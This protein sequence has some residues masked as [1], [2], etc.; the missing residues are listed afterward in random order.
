M[1]SEVQDIENVTEEVDKSAEEAPL[2]IPVSLELLTLVSEWRAQHG[3]KHEDYT[4]Y[5]R[6][7]SRKLM[8]IRRTLHCQC[9]QKGKYKIAP[10]LT[11]DDLTQEKQLFVCLVSAERCWSYAM[12]LKVTAAQESR[13]KHRQVRK[14]SKAVKHSE[15]L[16]T[17][18]ESNRTD[19]R[20]KLETS[21][22]RDWLIGTLSLEKLEWSKAVH[23]FSNCKAV[24]EQLSA[25]V[26]PGQQTFYKDIASQLE[27]HLRYCRYSLK[28][29]TEAGGET[30]SA[31]LELRSSDL[32]GPLADKIEEVLRQTREKADT[33]ISEVKWLGKSVPIRSGRVHDA[34]RIIEEGG[35]EVEKATGR[36]AKLKHFARLLLDCQEAVQSIK[37]EI[38]IEK[39]SK[40]LQEK[41]HRLEHLGGLLDYINYCKL[42]HSTSRSLLMLEQLIKPDRG[43]EGGR[44]EELVRLYDILLQNN[45]DLVAIQGVEEMMGM[46]LSVRRAEFQAH[47]CFYLAEVYLT[48]ARL[49]EGL[50]LLEKAA[51]HVTELEKVCAD[52]KD[53]RVTSILEDSEIL[54]GDIRSKRCAALASLCLG[55]S[56]GDILTAPSRPK[57]HIADCLEHYIVLD[58]TDKL[59]DLQIV[60]FPPDYKPAPCKPYFFDLALNHVTFPE[61]ESHYS[62]RGGVL[63]SLFKGIWSS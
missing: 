7:C 6:Y 26:S 10:V 16:Y 48:A 60:S 33:G 13:H 20:S 47:R 25:V 61:L 24:Y 5:R 21:A 45:L 43:V 37:D 54:N 56:A 2:S 50:A 44:P 52:W 40:Q 41:E 42:T 27:L 49:N 34:I 3:L 22:Y 29:G 58:S 31:L 53:T 38:G 59:E 11:P 1:A 63:S 46:E 15:E 32:S 14:L 39:Q 55:S 4:R 28:L 19:A 12:E 51:R 36:E 35:K 18:T 17:L 30:E 23:S 57:G 9:T 62:K 8:R